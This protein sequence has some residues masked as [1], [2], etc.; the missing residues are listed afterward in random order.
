MDDETPPPSLHAPPRNCLNCDYRLPE[1]AVLCPNCGWDSRSPYVSPVLHNPGSPVQMA[2]RESGGHM[3][4]GVLLGSLLTWC[5]W[6]LAFAGPLISLI[7][8]FSVR[9]GKPTFARGIL[10]GILVGAIGVVAC[11][12]AF[13]WPH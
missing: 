5:F 2:H 12:A 9:N 10:I 13:P 8:Y 11:L 7:V 6:W 4:W 3:V 1:G